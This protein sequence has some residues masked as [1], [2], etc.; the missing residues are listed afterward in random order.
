MA[1]WS[2]KLGVKYGTIESRFYKRW[3]VSRILTEPVNVSKRNTRAR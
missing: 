3:P 1:E 2:R